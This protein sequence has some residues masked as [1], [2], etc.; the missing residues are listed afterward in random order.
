MNIDEF[1]EDRYLDEADKWDYKYN[2]VWNPSKKNPG[3][4]NQ[5]VT[6]RPDSLE[7]P[8]PASTQIAT[9][10]PVAQ[11]TQISTP[12]YFDPNSVQ[13]MI[14]DATAKKLAQ[15]IWQ[16][17]NGKL[18]SVTGR[19]DVS[20]DDVRQY[21]Q[22]AKMLLSGIHLSMQEVND[23]IR[24]VSPT[25]ASLYDNFIERKRSEEDILPFGKEVSDI[26]NNVIKASMAA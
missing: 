12:Q 2:D 22:Y 14:P 5:I 1:L 13:L 18:G 19:D 8:A 24:P 9:P 6:G 20:K 26:L 11:Q 21:A 25:L 10:A 16:E 15:D 17:I 7:Y 3:E 4:D 23:Y